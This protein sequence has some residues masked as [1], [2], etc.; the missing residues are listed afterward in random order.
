MRAFSSIF[1]LSLLACDEIDFE[2]K[3]DCETEDCEEWDDWEEEGDWDEEGESDREDD[4]DE[5]GESDRE[6]DW[7]EE[8]DREDDW[9]EEEDECDE[10]AHDWYEECLDEG[11]DL[12][13]CASWA[14]EVYVDC[15]ERQD[16]EDYREGECEDAFEVYVCGS[17]K[18]VA[19]DCYDEEDEDICDDVTLFALECYQGEVDCDDISGAVEACLDADLDRD[20]CLAVFDVYEVCVMVEAECEDD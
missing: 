1:L 2:E 5:E 7:D 8:E 9:D 18:E 19:E 13:E 4:W 15:V 10:Y 6:D 3:W 20:L 12:E 11:G 16:D 14:E 17:L